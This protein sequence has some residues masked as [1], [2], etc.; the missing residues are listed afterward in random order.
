LFGSIRENTN[1]RNGKMILTSL[2]LLLVGLFAG[3][4]AANFNC[5][6]SIDDAVTAVYLNDVDVTSSVSGDLTNWKTAKSLSLPVPTGNAVLAILGK[7]AG[8]AAS[9]YQISGLQLE[10]TGPT[11]EWNFFSEPSTGWKALASSS[12][13]GNSFPANWATGAYDDSSWSEVVSSTSEFYLSDG[14]R[15]AKK[16]WIGGGS[17]S[18][19]VA[20]R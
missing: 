1:K 9:S 6:F 5:F 4:S 19:Y 8:T 20:F 17:T 18:T 10:C 11:A 15:P 2:L 13:T 7:E 12:S 3:T 16:I 14:S